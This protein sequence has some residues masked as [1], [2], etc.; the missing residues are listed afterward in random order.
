MSPEGGYCYF[1]RFFEKLK[2]EPGGV[3]WQ[4]VVLKAGQWL[5]NGRACDMF[6]LCSASVEPLTQLERSPC[7]GQDSSLEQ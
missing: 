2:C 3:N 5:S 7:T 6:G 4:G 1:I